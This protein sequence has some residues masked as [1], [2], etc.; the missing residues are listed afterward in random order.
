[1]KAKQFDREELEQLLARTE[2]REAPPWL[3]PRIMAEI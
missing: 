1:M 3:L 2:E